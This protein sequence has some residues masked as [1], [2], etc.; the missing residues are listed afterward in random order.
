MKPPKLGNVLPYCI[1]QVIDTKSFKWKSLC[2]TIDAPNNIE[3]AKK[4]FS[5]KYSNLWV[6]HCYGREPLF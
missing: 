6:K 3:D 2:K 4:R 1:I 5:K